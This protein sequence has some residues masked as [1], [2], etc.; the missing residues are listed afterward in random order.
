MC[1][2]SVRSFLV[3]CLGA[4][5]VL[6]ACA[7]APAETGARAQADPVPTTEPGSPAPT[8]NDGCIAD[9]DARWNQCCADSHRAS[10][11][12][13]AGC[14]SGCC[15]PNANSTTVADCHG[16]TSADSYCWTDLRR[17]RHGAADTHTNGDTYLAE[18]GL[19]CRPGRS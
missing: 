5:L 4:I 1:H 3:T 13:N 15:D 19:L 12:R 2:T 16:D 10:Q 7:S 6:S 8:P 9:S 18:P 11:H 17:Y 14:N